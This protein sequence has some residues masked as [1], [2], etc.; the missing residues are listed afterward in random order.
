MRILKENP[1]WIFVSGQ[2]GNVEYRKLAETYCTKNDSFFIAFFLN[3]GIQINALP[4]TSYF[5]TFLDSVWKFRF[6]LFLNLCM[7]ILT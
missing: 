5:A 3:Q 6:V 7:S 2:T 4:F 1:S